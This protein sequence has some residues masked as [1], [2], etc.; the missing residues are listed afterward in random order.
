M[1]SNSATFGRLRFSSVKV[2]SMP[3]PILTSGNVVRA[4]FA[5]SSTDGLSGRFAPGCQDFRSAALETT[6]ESISKRARFAAAATGLSDASA[7]ASSGTMTSRTIFAAAAS[8]TFLILSKLE[9]AAPSRRS[10]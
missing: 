4:A 1:K 2:E 6:I 5:I 8:P 9:R 3:P 10:A 7:L